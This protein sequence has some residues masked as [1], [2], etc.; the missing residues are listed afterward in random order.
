MN[1][2]LKPR[3]DAPTDELRA[4][5]SPQPSPLA[6]EEAGWPLSF[7]QQRLWFLDQLEP[8]TPLYNIP[9]V[10]RLRGPLNVAA[11]QLALDTIVERHESLRTRFVNQG[12]HPA[13][14]FDEQARLR[15]QVQDLS[16]ILET[17]RDAE[18]QRR[19]EQEVRR[20]FNLSTDQ[21]I[22]ASLLKLKPD[23]HVLVVNMHHIVSDEWSFGIFYR[24]LTALYAGFC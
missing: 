19:V 7:S 10:A 2:E 4:E 14:V 5:L 17:A 6:A 15:L 20:P 8:N 24:E 9:S 13:Q 12:G 23:E 11:L 3:A 21:L 1:V 18:L 22:R 16:G